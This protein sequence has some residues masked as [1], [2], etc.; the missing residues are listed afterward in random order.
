MNYGYLLICAVLSFS[1][2][3]LAQSLPDLMRRHDYVTVKARVSAGNCNLEANDSFNRTVLH[4][5]AID[6]AELIPLLLDKGANI[7]A[8]DGSGMTPLHHAIV[9]GNIDSVRMLLARNADVKA[10]DNSRNTAMLFACRARDN[11]AV[12]A[13]FLL[14][15]GADVNAANNEGMTPF[16]VVNSTP[17]YNSKLIS[18]IFSAKPELNAQN[19]H[20]ETA[21]M[22]CLTRY[23]TGAPKIPW[24]MILHIPGLNFD[25]QDRDGY[26]AMNQLA[27]VR[28]NPDNTALLIDALCSKG[29]NPNIPDKRGRTPLYNA[30]SSDNMKAVEYLLE[31][32]NADPNLADEDGVT[33]LTLAERK[34][35]PELIKMLRA[36]NAK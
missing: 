7:E 17:P 4:W 10:I 18:A 24:A 16:M 35:N 6:N 11:A 29:A 32:Y 21:L 13:T 26:T 23:A 15:H 19:N 25:L 2:M 27:C 36:K 5:A 3:V 34:R 1:P 31:R 33:P 30:I 9:A 12:L 28:A 22:L 8:R 14:Q 20:G